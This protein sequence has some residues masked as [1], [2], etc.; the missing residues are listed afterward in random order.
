MSTDLSRPDSSPAGEVPDGK[1]NKGASRRA[2]LGKMGAAA[3]LAAGSLA[4]AA[5]ASG[6]R[7]ESQHFSPSVTA[8]GA[9]NERVV[10]AFELR[11]DSAVR[12]ARIPA[13]KNVSNGDEGRYADK[14]GT[15]TKG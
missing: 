2:C 11:V 4:T 3:T 12:D 8:S 1:A 15:Y 13:A 5:T 7:E 10:E 6:Q 9:T 14:A